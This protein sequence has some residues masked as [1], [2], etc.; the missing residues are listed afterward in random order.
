MSDDEWLAALPKD[1]E[2]LTPDGGMRCRRNV[3]GEGDEPQ[4]SPAHVLIEVWAF[5]VMWV[6][7]SELRTW[8]RYTP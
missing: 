5:G 4:P 7:V 6:L 2:W 8:E 3:P 1:A